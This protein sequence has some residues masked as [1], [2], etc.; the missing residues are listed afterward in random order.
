MNRIAT[1]AACLAVLP[2]SIAWAQDAL[3]SEGPRY[4]ADGSLIRPADYREWVF[5]SSGFNMT[6][7]PNAPNPA[8]NQPFNNVFVNRAAYRDFV[9]T[10][11]WP[12]QTIFILEIRQSQEHIRPN[13]FGYTQA[14]AIA[15]E[16]AVKDARNGDNPWAYYSFDAEGGLSANAQPLP[17]SAGCQ[18]C[19]A[20]HTAVEQTF[21]QFYPV[22]LDIAKAK[23]TIKASWDP[24]LDI[25]APRVSP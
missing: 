8:R 20:E 25:Q 19:H 5:L 6:Y 14:A 22:L 12:D 21:V 18:E 13:T 23:G 15:M 4:N 11:R 9:E 1:L 24:A 10:G 16:A 7:G 2:L 3:E 17:V